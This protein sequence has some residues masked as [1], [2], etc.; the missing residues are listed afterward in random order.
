MFDEKLQAQVI[1][2]AE[3]RDHVTQLEAERALAFSTGLAAIDS[4]MDD[5][6]Q[7]LD[8]WRYAYVTTAV[9]ETAT[10]R[11]ELFGANAG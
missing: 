9:T 11:A 10:L 7:E 6:E 2:A 4:Y 1:T 8:L 3:A 5:L